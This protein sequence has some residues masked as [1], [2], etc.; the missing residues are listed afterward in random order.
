MIIRKIAFLLLWLMIFSIPWQGMVV[1]PGLGTFTR[2][3]G[4]AVV[5]VAGL[6]ILIGKKVKDPPLFLI[7]ASIFVLWSFITI[8]WSINQGATLQRFITFIQL[9]A[10]V[11]LIWQLCETRKH[12]LTIMQA[13]VLGSYVTLIDMIITFTT[14]VGAVGR[15]V[16]TGFNANDIASPL[17]IGIAIAWYLFLKNQKGIMSWVN[18]LFI[19]CALFGIILTGTRGGLIVAG[20]SLLLIPLTVFELNTR[21]RYIIVTFLILFAVLASIYLPSIYPRIEENVERMREIPE[22]ITEGTMT[23]RTVIWEAGLRVYRENPIIGVGALGYRYA[24]V[25]STVMHPTRESYFSEPKSSHNTFLSVLVD[26]GLIGFIIFIT[27]L[28]IVVIPVFYLKSTERIFGILLFIALIVSMMPMA[29]E[30]NKL[31]WYIFSIL[32]L[33]G[34]LILRRGNICILNR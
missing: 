20:I 9:L 28:I 29:W 27:V 4:F 16:P 3:V 6:Y 13:F 11:W 1:L 25:G 7:V 12:I 21:G 24:V 8:L 10:M 23:G 22:Q 2:F 18:M 15:V 19:P 31:V 34:A 26:T 14:S 33:Q 32:T 17:G 30:A 5:A